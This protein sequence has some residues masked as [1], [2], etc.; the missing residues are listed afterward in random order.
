M[1]QPHAEPGEIVS[2]RP[3][4]AQLSEAT[5]T[6]ILKASQLEIIRVVLPAGK[7]MREHHTPGEITVQCLEGV[8]EFETDDT[9]QTMQAG[10]LIHLAPRARHALKAL[11][12]ASLLLTICL[13]PG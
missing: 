7:T 6:A 13:L 12:N 3:L 4:G 5:S 9:T 10:D 8:V 11:E 2:V 1:A